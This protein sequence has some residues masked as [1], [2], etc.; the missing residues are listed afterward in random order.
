MAGSCSTARAAL[1]TVL[2]SMAAR[3]TDGVPNRRPDAAEPRR[4]RQ[5]EQ[6]RTNP[7]GTTAQQLGQRRTNP[8]GTTAQQPAADGAGLPTQSTAA[9]LIGGQRREEGGPSAAAAVSRSQ[10]APDRSFT[11]RVRPG[12][13]PGASTA[14]FLPS[15]GVDAT[16]ATGRAGAAA[17]TATNLSVDRGGGDL[18]FYGVDSHA[19]GGKV[20]GG[21]SIST[22]THAPTHTHMHTHTR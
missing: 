5:G 11:N 18:Q 6:R 15:T 8:P 2:L 10:S 17:A 9:R 20:T 12:S 16:G 7:P 13:S 22:N 1:G 19:S 4:K 21:I 14:T 3:G